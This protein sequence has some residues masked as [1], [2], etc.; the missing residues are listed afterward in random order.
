MSPRPVEAREPRP[1][2]PRPPVD[3]P[4]PE[5]RAPRPQIERAE[6]PVQ[7][8]TT[9]PEA[10]TTPALRR[11]ID[12]MKSSFLPREE[13]ASVTR[14]TVLSPVETL[15]PLL[16]VTRDDTTVL[17]GS[18]FGTLNRF[19]Q[20]YTTFPDMRLVASESSRLSAWILM[21][22]SIDVRPFQTILPGIG[23]PPIY[24]TRDI[25]AK[26]RNSITDTDFLAQC[27]FFELFA[28][29]RRAVRLVHFPSLRQVL[30]LLSQVQQR[31]Y[32][33]TFLSQGQ[34]LLQR[35]YSPVH[36]MHTLLVQI[37]SSQERFFPS[38]D[39]T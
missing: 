15:D 38:A 19:G 14:M 36:Q 35:L 25:I 27:R 13:D 11:L 29:G 16:L 39:E 5:M 2:A 21:D 17:V 7:R 37:V 33:L 20:E 26:F 3:A 8:A 28:D 34:L 9:A 1:F 30:S 24:A 10:P 32:S 23:F 12:G 6:R 18:G 4:R 31:S 22:G